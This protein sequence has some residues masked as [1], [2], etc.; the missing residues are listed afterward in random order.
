MVLDDLLIF[1]CRNLWKDK[2]WEILNIK[3]YKVNKPIVL[4]LGGNGVID[5]AKATRFCATAERFIGLKQGDV[6]ELYKMA[7]LLGFCYTPLPHRPTIGEFNDE[8][9][10]LIADNIFIKLCVDDEGKVLPIE[11]TIKNFSLINVFTHCWGARE[12]SRIGAVVK[13]KMMKMGYSANDVQNAF[14]QIHH[15]TYAPYTDH[16]PFPCFRINSFIDSEHWGIHKI[17]KEVYKETLNGIALH[18]DKAGY[19]R[20]VK[21]PILEVP[22]ISLYSSQLI[23]TKEN[24]DIRKLIDEHPAET[25]ERNYDWTQGRQ[26]RAAVNADVVS[27]MASYF[28]AKAVATS[29]QNQKSKILI[30]KED[31]FVLYEDLMDMLNSYAPVILETGIEL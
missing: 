23:N 1:G 14:N 12:I 18:Y 11:Q 24:S 9:R 7:D 8:Q 16:S 27:M 5:I 26:Q 22:I 25:L 28:L 15:L 4:C 13:N 10:E 31:M 20:Q 6:Y 3:D 21:S 17:Y 29:V 19:F 30:P 2:H